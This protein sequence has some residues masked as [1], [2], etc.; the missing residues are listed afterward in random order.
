MV[1]DGDVDDQ[2]EPMARQRKRL[3]AQLATFTDDQW[4][5]HSRCTDWTVRDVIAHLVGVNQFWTYSVKCALAGNPSR[6]LANF[7]PAGTPA[8]MVA[9]MVAISTSEVLAQFVFSNREFLASLDGLTTA[10]WG[11]LGESPAGH[12]PLRLVAQHALWDSWIHERDIMVPLGLAQVEEPDELTSCLRYVAALSPTFTISTGADIGGVFGVSA[13]RPTITFSIAVHDTVT[14]SQR[15]EFDGITLMGDA[16]ELVEALS[17]RAP[18]PD[19]APEAWQ[20]L[21]TGITRAMS[22]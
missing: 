9:G 5:T 14:C 21:L 17:L 19:D 11:M 18:L 12:V 3:E 2:L 20:Q 15:A 13:R 6:L 4:Q 10:Q 8:E 7:D 16:T 1:F 22:N